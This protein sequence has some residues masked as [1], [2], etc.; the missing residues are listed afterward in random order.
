MKLDVEIP[1]PLKISELGHAQE[2]SYEILECLFSKEDLG[3]NPDLTM[4]FMG[5]EIGHEEAFRIGRF[6][7]AFT[8]LARLNKVTYLLNT[9]KELGEDMKE[10][11][12]DYVK[13]EVSTLKELGLCNH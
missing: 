3:R 6:I 8:V 5:F 9:S 13:S 1:K 10:D 4:N 7:D 12:Q 11:I 2:N